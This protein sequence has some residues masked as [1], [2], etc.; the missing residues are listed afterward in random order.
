MTDS[1]R[2]PEGELEAAIAGIGRPQR[3]SEEAVFRATVQAR[4]TNL[5]ADLADVK[6]RLN[7]LLFFIASTVIAQVVLKLWA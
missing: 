2:T 7:G 1:R 4:L 5:E 3:L 6:S